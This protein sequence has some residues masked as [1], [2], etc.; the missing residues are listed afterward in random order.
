MNK[1]KLTPHICSASHCQ[2]KVSA[3]GWCASHY[4]RWRKYGDPELTAKDLRKAS[5]KK[6]VMKDCDEAVVAKSL[7]RKHYRRMLVHGTPAKV[8]K[9]KPALGHDCSVEGCDRERLAGGLCNLH[10]NRL[11][12]RGDVGGPLPES[13]RKPARKKCTVEGC[14]KRHAARGLCS[15]HYKRWRIKNRVGQVCKVEGCDSMV[16]AKELCDMHYWRWIRH[17]D[18]NRGRNIVPAGTKRVGPGGYIMIKVDND[19]RYKDGWAREHRAVMEESLGRRLLTEEN[20]HHINGDVA[21]NRRENLELWN[22]SQPAGQRPEDK[23][24]HAL[25]IIELYGKP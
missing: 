5:V 7:C 3:R 18:V 13:N 25:H 22:T 4:N 21:D 8:Q 1:E 12:K 9:F 19:E 16:D 24:A 14:G 11:I 23:L 17:G 6:C 10:Y 15:A 20:V 2:K